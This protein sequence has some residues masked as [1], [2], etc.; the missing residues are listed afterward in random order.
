MTEESA[1]RPETDKR[2]RESLALP[3]PEFH[4]VREAPDPA[5]PRR[6]IEGPHACG[7]AELVECAAHDMRSS[8]FALQISL[9]LLERDAGMDEL[10]REDLARATQAAALLIELVNLLADASRRLSSDD[11]RGTDAPRTELRRLLEQVIRD[12]EGARISVV[13]GA[14][15]WVA[16]APDLVREVLARLL[17]AVVGMSEARASLG[18]GAGM[19]TVTIELPRTETPNGGSNHRSFASVY[20]RIV[21]ESLGGTLVERRGEGRWILRLPL[22]PPS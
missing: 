15:L 19:A 13:P 11:D 8:L 18:V 5:L 6:P 2:I 4:R 16:C 9:R 7:H 14:D 22:V 12:V 21:L 17:P 1:G 10:G 20:C 3:D